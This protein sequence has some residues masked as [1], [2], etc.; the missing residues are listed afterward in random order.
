[1]TNLMRRFAEV[2]W[3]S[4]R[5]EEQER[6]RYEAAIDAYAGREVIVDDLQGFQRAESR[7]AAIEASLNL[8]DTEAWPLKSDEEIREIVDAVVSGEKLDMVVAKY[9]ESYGDTPRFDALKMAMKPAGSRSK[10]AHGP[11]WKTHVTST[12]AGWSSRKPCPCAGQRRTSWT[13]QAGLRTCRPRRLEGGHRG[14]PTRLRGGTGE[15]PR[16]R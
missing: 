6:Q 10:S 13:G 14:R 11:Q 15:R 3:S 9:E 5:P 12:S 8:G 4:T 16:S 7:I 1:M 2:V